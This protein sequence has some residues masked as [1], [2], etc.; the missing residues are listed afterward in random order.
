MKQF[1]RFSILLL[2]LLLPTSAVAHIFEVDG[3]YYNINGNEV[4]VTYKGSYKSEY[5]NEYSGNV[6][7]PETVTY[8]G[9]TFSVASIGEYAFFDCSSLTSVTIP[10][11]VTSISDYAFA[12]CSSLTSVEIPNSVTSIGVCAFERCSGLTSVTIPN[13][14][15][16]IGGHA[17][18]GTPWYDNQPDGLVYAGL[19]AYK[20]KG[21]MP[22]GTQINLSNGT[23]G[24]AGY[25]F[26]DCSGLTSVEIPNTV[27][28]I[29][30]RAF[31][32]CSGLTS[33]EIPNSVTSI[34]R[35]AF[36]GCSGL[37]S[38]TIPNSVT[39]IG[40]DAFKSTGWYDN[41]P[42]G[43]VYAGLVAY[44]YKG[45]MPAGTQID[46]SNGTTSITGYA[47]QSCR[48]LTS[49][50]I[51]NSVIAI[52]DR[53]FWSCRGLTSVTIPN[54]VI[55]IGRDAF[56]NCTGLTSVTLGNSVTTLFLQWPD[57]RDDPEF[58]HFHQRLC[59]R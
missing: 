39:T 22:A 30:D 33:V 15:T 41:Q 50:T 13:S 58:R 29:N 35:W 19:V 23:T 40:Y 45:T 3:I 2:A 52:G 18:T 24:I 38:V 25:A 5:D 54:S 56:Y 51:P 17:F 43:L 53:A 7:I 31:E 59:I 12:D 46:L 37:M 57:E 11:S 4:T 9:T 44:K 14:V 34:G 36:Q 55:S 28:T 48:G 32:R 42:D 8:K 10:N 20:Y 49:V 21:T 16:S 6:I 26:Q 1:F 47:F 27:I